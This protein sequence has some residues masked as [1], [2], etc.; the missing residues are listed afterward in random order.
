MKLIS[1]TLDELDACL[2]SGEARKDSIPL[3]DP[4]GLL[5]ATRRRKGLRQMNTTRLSLT[6]C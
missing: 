5:W 6:G 3:S 1:F 2:G 4:D